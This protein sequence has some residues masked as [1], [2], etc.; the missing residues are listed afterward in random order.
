MSEEFDR[1][2][3]KGRTVKDF[4]RE[5]RRAWMAKY[6]DEVRSGE[7]EPPKKYIPPPPAKRP[8]PWTQPQNPWAAEAYLIPKADG[9]IFDYIRR[10]FDQ[11][12]VGILPDDWP[13]RPYGKT[14]NQETKLIREDVLNIIKEIYGNR[15][16]VLIRSVGFGHE[17]LDYIEYPDCYVS[18]HK[19]YWRTPEQ[20]I[21][22]LRQMIMLPL[23]HLASIKETIGDLERELWVQLQR[24]HDLRL[25]PANSTMVKNYKVRM[26]DM[27]KSIGKIRTCLSPK[28]DSELLL[29]PLRVRALYNYPDLPWTEAIRKEKAKLIPDY[30][31]NKTRNMCVEDIYE[32][33]RDDIK[34]SE[35][36]YIQQKKTE[37]ERLRAIR[38]EE[39][40]NAPPKQRRRR[41]KNGAAKSPARKREKKRGY[42][43]P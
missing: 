21:T 14:A 23:I 31:T 15:W 17:V 5:E 9:P 22:A 4:T 39:K 27:A 28:Y 38:E 37:R 25:I 16:R 7:R 24:T 18:G 30:W 12:G 40:E 42:T 32:E 26:D 36:E 19:R 41:R 6:W 43:G 20:K 33:W 13:Q 2:S 11:F 1:K 3:L 29:M 35:L 8:A 34:A 10:N